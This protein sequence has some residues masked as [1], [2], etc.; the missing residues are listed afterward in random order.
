[1][2]GIVGYVS[3][4][5]GR[6]DLSRAVNSLSHRGP[7]DSGTYFN[8]SVGMGHTRLSIIDLSENG[9]QPKISKNENSAIAFN[10]EIYNFQELALKLCIEDKDIGDTHVLLEGLNRVGIDFIQQ[11]RGMY[12]FSFFNRTTDEFFL[13]K[14]RLGI[15]PLYYYHDDD[16][17][18][19][20]SE[21]KAIRSLVK[22]HFKLKINHQAIEQYLRFGFVPTPNTIYEGI[23]K[24]EP[25]CYLKYKKGNL[26]I[27]KYW[28]SNSQNLDLPFESAVDQLDSLLNHSIQEHLISDVPIGA[29]LS[30][31]IDSG[32][33]TAIAQ[34]YS[35]SRIKTFT[36][37]FKEAKFDESIYARSIAQYLK[38]D[39]HEKII[40]VDDALGF[41]QSMTSIY[42]EPFAD[43][44]ALP[45]L[46]LTK[47][48]REHVKVMLSGDGGD[49][50]FYGY[51]RYQWANR[52]ETLEK[53]RL[54]TALSVLLRFLP[55]AKYQRASKLLG[56]ALSTEEIFSQ[57]SL[58]FS[59]GEVSRLMR[60]SQKGDSLYNPLVSLKNQA[61]FDLK[62]YL[63]D[64][65]LT[66]VD[67]ASMFN[68]LEV[69]VPL[70]DHRIVEFGRAIPDHFKFSGGITKKILKEVLFR[71]LPSSL[72]DRPK[73]G[74]SIPLSSWLK[75]DLRNWMDEVLDR[76]LIEEQNILNWEEVNRLRTGFLSGEEDNFNKVWML[77]ILQDF[78]RKELE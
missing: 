52:V 2:C 53:F 42:D 18:L 4:V 31:G 59:K 29:F 44:S 60:D 17:L 20:A 19:F 67:R 10:G 27:C 8:D 77:T 51:N 73:Q 32:I 64:D 11:L 14:D 68:S 38:T 55:T 22:G 37:G 46:L 43:S 72:Y 56:S 3:K 24:L 65:N 48:A 33:V 71:Y 47:Y 13:V 62:Y 1:M 57:T 66:K 9:H 26:E 23:R 12:A 49:E 70:L 54:S 45:T 78:L 75:N 76:D 28:K 21:L 61:E 36:I 6:D 34:K 63:P 40:Q 58:M 7:D 69:R 74:F 16:N 15:K 25:G 5:F 35:G 50:I 41:V 39:H 30:G